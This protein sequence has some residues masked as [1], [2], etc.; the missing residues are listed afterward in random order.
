[1]SSEECYS[2]LNIPPGTNKQEIKRAYWKKAKMYH[3]DVNSSTDAH[4][5]FVLVKEAYAIL[6]Q[7]KPVAARIIYYTPTQYN[8]DPY[9]PET[10]QERAARHAR[11]QY[12][13][14]KRNNEKFKNSFWY[15][16]FLIF[17]Y[18]VLFMGVCVALGFML[19]PLVMIFINK[20]LGLYMMPIV[21][22]GFAVMT[23]VFRFKN[24][25][26]R[27]FFRIYP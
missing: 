27:Y 13:E 21:L 3:P 18:F 9:R 11:M 5:Q 4:K 20:M 7:D 17:S 19:T 25:I 24:E 22:M 2:I 14:F 26:N 12:E 15:F 10:R 16:P 8:K 1:M 6:T 23:G